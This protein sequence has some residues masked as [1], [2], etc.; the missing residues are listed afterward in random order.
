[1]CSRTASTPSTHRSSPPRSRS[2]F[3]DADELWN[4]WPEWARWDIYQA[5]I[6]YSTKGP[7]A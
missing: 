1:M 5:V 7:A 3:D 2:P 4:E 6:A